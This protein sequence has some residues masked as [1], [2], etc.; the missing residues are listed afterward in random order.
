M[1]SPG[2][3]PP[4]ATASVSTTLTAAHRAEPAIGLGAAPAARRPARVAMRQNGIAV[5]SPDEVRV[6]AT[7]LQRGE[8]QLVGAQ[9]ARQRMRVRGASTSVGAADDDPGL[10]SAE[11]LVAGE[12][13]ERGAG[14]DALADAEL[15]AQPRGSVAA[16][17][18]SSRRAD[19]SPASTTPAGRVRASSATGVDVDEP[20]HAVVR[21]VHLQ[22]ERDVVGDSARS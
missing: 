15:V 20:D 2:N 14:V 21:R 1:V 17:T 5:A 3:E 9:R 7:V 6:S 11:Q 12:G 22:H 19:P 13:H 18:A 16:A 4:P 10:R 8:R